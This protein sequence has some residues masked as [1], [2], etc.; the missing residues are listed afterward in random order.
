M[1]INNKGRLEIVFRYCVSE[2]DSKRGLAWGTWWVDPGN[3]HTLLQS[4]YKQPFN[5]F[6]DMRLPHGP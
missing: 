3:T 6:G 5:N 2:F 4:K 1:P